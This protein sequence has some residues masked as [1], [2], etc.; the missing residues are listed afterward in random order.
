[1]DDHREQEAA[2]RRRAGAAPP[3]VSLAAHVGAP[4]RHDDHPAL[5]HVHGP[6]GRHASDLV[7]RRLRA[8][9]V[10]RVRRG[11]YVDAAAWAVLDDEARHRARVRAVVAAAAGPVTLSHWSAAAVLGLPAVGRRDDRVHLVRPPAEG[12][13]SH[14]DVVRHTVADVPT[15]VLVDGL[16][17]TA[18]ART[19]VDLARLAGA[20]AGVAAADA[21]VRLGLTTTAELAD[22]VERAARGRGVR[23]ARVVAALVDPLAESPGESLSRVRMAELGAPAPVLQHEVHDR[24]GFV[25]RVDFWWPEHGVVGEFDGR[26]K[27]AGASHD[28]LWREKLRE[29]R[30]RALGLGVAR[31]TWADAWA[32]LP[33]LARLRAAGV[34]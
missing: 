10:V 5:V 25:G 18:P 8:G 20:A 1:M 9:E 22:E 6:R 23:A 27:Y 24:H 11:T 21:A 26:V 30:I 17:C 28:V 14:R 16:R 29:D 7:R 33:M 2:D 3:P 34:R 15:V 32:G 4:D 12:G 31:W 19:V 13:R